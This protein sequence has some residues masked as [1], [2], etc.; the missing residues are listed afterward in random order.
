MTKARA[1][2]QIMKDPVCGMDVDPNNSESFTHKGQTYYFCS[3]HCLTKFKGDPEKYLSKPAQDDRS[4]DS[5]DAIYTCPMHSEIRQN[6]PGSCPICGM[7][8]EPLEITLEEGPNEE[9][10]DMKRRLVVSTILTSPLLILTMGEMFAP[11]FISPVL[12]AW[13]QFILSTPVVVWAG[14]PLFE[15]AWVSFRTWNLNMFSLIGI[16]TGVAYVY[17]LIAL[18]FPHLF[19]QSAAGHSGS[20]N[21]YFEPAAVI[22]ALVLLGQ[23]LELKARSQTSQ[24]LKSLLNLAPKTARRIGSDGTEEEVA[25][26]L[27]HLGD[28]LRVRPGEKIPVD[29]VV[30]EGHSSVDESMITGEPIPVE[31]VHESPVTGGTVNQTGSFVMQAKRVGSETLLSQIVKMVSEAQRSRAPIQKLADIVSSYFVPAVIVISV[32]TAVVWAVWGPPPALA[33]AI[34]NAVAV[35]II[36]CPCALGLATPMSVMVGTGRGA[37]AGILIKNAEALEVFSKVDTLVVDKTGTL[38]VGKPKVTTIIPVGTFSE[39]QI[40]QC[41][42]S[43]EQGSEHPLAHA[44]VVEAKARNLKVNKTEKFQ[45]LTGKGVEGSV[46]GKTVSFGNQ[47]LMDEKGVSTEPFASKA[48]ALRTDGQT[49]MFVAINNSLAGMIG[50]SDPIKSDAAASLETLRGLGLKIVMLTGDNKTTASA[51]AKKLGISELYAEVLPQDKVNAVKKLQEQGR[52]VAM[53]GDGINDA[54]ALAKANVGL[55][56]G[57][58][59]DVALESAG[60]TLIKG[61]L[62]A[63]VRARKLSTATMRNIRQNLFFAFI[64]NALGVPIAAGVLYPVWGVL[65]NP[66][67]AS[68]AMS[69]SSVSVIANALRLKRAKL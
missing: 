16:G 35:L 69:L 42:A 55:A 43:L 38:T 51:V 54:P 24:A 52:I 67:L 22:I 44:I 56:M 59:T 46:D 15:K 27:I 19:P 21:L 57:T 34:V 23:V 29:G 41:T 10:L 58:G 33:H 1:A 68:L 13:I 26:N 18:F 49:V 20:V 47:R 25:L 8:L 48:D 66:M 14:Y 7:A 11:R 17:S 60:I 9:F 64:Y 4:V 30:L 39:E 6:G 37:H 36:A 28:H 45:S 3:S 50:V 65:L 53:A 40:L 2:D 32:V 31:K 63:L 61:E 62:S 5:S 12:M